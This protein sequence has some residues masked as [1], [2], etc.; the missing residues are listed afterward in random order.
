[1]WLSDLAPTWY[2]AVP[3]IHQAILDQV[4]RQ[5]EKAPNDHLRF[6]RSCSS[7]LPPRVGQDLEPSSMRPFWKLME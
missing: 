7:S 5:P 1:M 3:T 2:T 4:Q 6:I